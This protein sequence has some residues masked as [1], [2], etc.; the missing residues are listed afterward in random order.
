MVALYAMAFGLAAPAVVGAQEPDDEAAQPWTAE[1]VPV[2]DFAARAPFGPG[3]HLV[4]KVKVGIFNA[5]YGYMSVLGTEDIDDNPSYSVEMGIRG[6]FGPLSIDDKY[7]SWFDVSTFQSWRYI[8]DIDEVAY[9]AFRHYEFDLDAMEWLRLDNGE[10]GP[11]GSAL[12][13]DEIAF[14]YFIRS[15]EL[16]VGK[17][18]TINRFFKESGNPVRIEVLRRDEREV[19][20]VVYNTIVVKPLIRTSGLF[21]EGGNAELHFTDDERRLLVYLNSNIP[22]FPGGLSL[23]LQTVQD[24]FPLHPESRAA[25]L[26]GREAR[27]AETDR[28]R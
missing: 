11:L 22:N 17:S 12:P 21:G 15:M 19:G 25:A 10:S 4:Y 9:E 13:M 8:Q 26:A 18:Y 14:I 3:E 7:Q 2:D 1:M 23:H 5:G 24:G 27:A 20:G 6:G 16:E 28:Q